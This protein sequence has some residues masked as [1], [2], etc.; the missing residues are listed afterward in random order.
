MNGYPLSRCAASPWKGDGAL[1][2]GAALAGR[3]AVC[4]APVVRVAG[5]AHALEHCH[6]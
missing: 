6:E 4:A 3:P 2:C 5:N 1:C